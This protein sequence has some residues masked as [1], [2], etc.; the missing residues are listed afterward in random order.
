MSLDASTGALNWQY[1]VDQLISTAAVEYGGNVY[2][3]AYKGGTYLYA[4]DPVRGAEPKIRN[5]CTTS[6]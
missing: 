1:E 6:L 2:F 5:T 4:I 3:G